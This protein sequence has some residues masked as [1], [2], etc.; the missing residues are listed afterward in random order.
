MQMVAVSTRTMAN[1]KPRFRTAESMEP[2]VKALRQEVANLNARISQMKD[3]HAA[4]MAIKDNRIRALENAIGDSVVREFEM[5]F[6]NTSEYRRIEQR[7]LK[8]A[9][10]THNQLI[11]P[12]CTFA[13][14]HARYCIM[15]WA[16]R[17]TSMSHPQIGKKLGKDHSTTIYGVRRWRDIRAKQGRNL[18]EVR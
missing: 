8:V 14:S 2:E 17:R 10:L 3:V 7:I 12:S 5:E 1:A 16:R 6:S 13:V 15:Y 11:S 18:R 4:E 9:K